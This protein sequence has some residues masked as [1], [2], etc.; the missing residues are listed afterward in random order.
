MKRTIRLLPLTFAL[1]ALVFL[2]MAC[3]T[4]A[5]KPPALK[6]PASKTS[7]EETMKPHASKSVHPDI[8]ARF[9][10]HPP[11]P[12][13]MVVKV[14]KDSAGNIGGYVHTL[15]IPDSP[16]YYL[17]NEGKSLAMFHIFGSDK[18]KTQNAPIISALRN[19]Y[20]VEENLTCP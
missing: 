16:I 10:G 9:C 6:P 12:D 17:D 19:A 2:P 5:F 20:P 1:S 14:L 4:S 18:E 8:I 3:R 7:K 13:P 15:K 11:G